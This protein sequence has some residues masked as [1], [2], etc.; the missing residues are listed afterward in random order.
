[1]FKEFPFWVKNLP[2]SR[3]EAV[4]E[5]EKEAVDQMIE[6]CKNGPVG[7]S[8]SDVHVLKEKFINEFIDFSISY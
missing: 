4:F 6:Y 5:G 1:M 2:D 3:I 7:A 8:I